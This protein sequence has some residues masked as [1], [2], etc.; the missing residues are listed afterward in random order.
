[1]DYPG[2]QVFSRAGSDGRR[3]VYSK[4]ILKEADEVERD[5]ARLTR[6]TF[7]GKAQQTRGRVAR[8][9][10]VALGKAP[11]F[12]SRDFELGGVPSLNLGGLNGSSA[13]SAAPARP[14][15]QKA[16]GGAGL[17]ARASN[18]ALQ[19]G[20]PSQRNLAIQTSKYTDA[21]GA[22]TQRNLGNQSLPSLTL[23][24]LNLGGQSL[25]S[26]TGSHLAGKFVSHKAT[27][28]TV[29]PGHGHAKG[30]AQVPKMLLVLKD[31][32]RDRNRGG[33]LPSQIVFPSN[34][35]SMRQGD[36]R[37]VD[38]TVLQPW[39]DTIKDVKLD[40]KDVMAARSKA[41]ACVNRSS[42]GALTYRY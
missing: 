12:G 30:E 35:V 33:V 7:V 21:G 22:S 16:V 39:D 17:R 13:S 5:G 34:A 20:S 26:L 29:R 4:I 15:P 28:N 9:P 2:T 14:A 27:G 3:R 31:E 36:R 25:P 10:P 32:E 11:S 18:N 38:A 23:G 40:F 6:V 37:T 19:G 41:N 42:H 1:M 24:D 8:E